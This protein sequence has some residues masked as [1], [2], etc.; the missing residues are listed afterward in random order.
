M[1][2]DARDAAYKDLTDAA[3]TAFPGL[4]ERAALHAYLAEGSDT[5]HDLHDAWLNE[6]PAQASPQA[7]AWTQIERL[8]ERL[9]IRQPAG[10][11][12]LTDAQAVDR[13][14]QTEEGKALFAKHQD[15]FRKASPT[16]QGYR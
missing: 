6:S 8:A 14:L 1:P 13:A 9:R 5:A 10:S 4:D 11:P 15:A 3:T 7:E 12:A 16:Y 2:T